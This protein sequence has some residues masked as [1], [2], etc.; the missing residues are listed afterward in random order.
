MSRYAIR[1]DVFGPYETIVL[2]DTRG[3]AKA[4]IARQ[5]AILLSW[6]VPFGGAMVDVTDGYAS[7]EEFTIRKGGRAWI[8]APFSNRLD[9]G[10]Y[11]FGGRFHYLGITDP[12]KRVILHGFLWSI[13]CDVAEEEATDAMAC[14]TLTTQAIRPGAFDGYFFAVNLAVTFTMNASRLE[15]RLAARNVGDTDAPFGCG[16]H[17]YFKTSPN[18]INH[19]KLSIPCRTVMMAD[20]RLLPLPGPAAYC[21][22][23]QA[24]EVDFRPGRP[25]DGNV[26]GTRVI[27]R[28]FADL[29][30]DAD[31]WIRTR[32]E[33]PINGMAISVFQERG[34][35]HAFTGD[36]LPTRP[37]GALAL[38]PIEFMTNA[39]NRPECREAIT[40]RP[41]RTRK[42]RF[43][44]EVES[45]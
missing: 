14:V 22:I 4:V 15:V 8:M 16:W 9:N 40:L 1:R 21:P 33:D 37:R 2:E 31:G 39:F 35:M 45:R 10:K 44:A 3:G 24:P 7:P 43:G 19:L 38:E 5:G 42:F 6:R 28:G 25:N 12:V 34:L 32:V 26:L 23:D 36:T 30:A 29:Q 27:D 41:G 20:D 11:E 13:V 18:G 17:P